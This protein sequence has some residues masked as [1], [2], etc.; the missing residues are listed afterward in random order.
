MLNYSP[1]GYLKDFF[2]FIGII[3][4]IYLALSLEEF[5][6]VTEEVKLQITLYIALILMVIY[7]G[8]ELVCDFL[9]DKFKS[10][11]IDSDMN[12]YDSRPLLRQ[13][14]SP[15]SDEELEVIAVHEVGHVML[16]SAFGEEPEDLY[17][18][19]HDRKIGVSNRGYVFFKFFD[20]DGKV[21]TVR[22]INIFML[23]NLSGMMAEK[24]Y[25][26]DQ[27][28]FGATQDMDK[29][30]YYAKLYLIHEEQSI[31]YNNPQNQFEQNHNA[32]L[33]S[34]LKQKQNQILSEFFNSNRVVLEELVCTLI[35]KKRLDYND[36]RSHLKKIININEISK[37]AIET[38][39]KF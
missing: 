32:Q 37:W 12:Q 2:K 39:R 18:Q 29:W 31:F 1:R 24:F 9:I 14:F 25:F 19:I 35:R 10:N 26:N 15:Y 27:R 28:L 4:C 22:D 3:L 38:N 33:L 36:L 30:L 11:P 16:F 20:R 21:L 17:V 7:A 13:N 5:S 6:E 34:D 23:I 8:Q